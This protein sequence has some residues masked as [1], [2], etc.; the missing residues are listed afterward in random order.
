M[1]INILVFMG[2]FCFCSSILSVPLYMLSFVA[3]VFFKFKTHDFVIKLNV[4]NSI[5]IYLVVIIVLCGIMHFLFLSVDAFIEI[6]QII[7]RVFYFINF[8]FIY[9]F[10][11]EPKNIKCLIK[12]ILPYVF[13]FLFIYSVY[14][15]F[16]IIYSL[17]TLGWIVN[18]SQFIV[19]DVKYSPTIGLFRLSLIWSEPSYAAI[20]L[21]FS[22]MFIFIYNNKFTKNWYCYMMLLFL[23][24]ILT[25][26]R[27]LLIPFSSIIIY[28]LIR[29]FNFSKIHLESYLK[30]LLVILFFMILHIYFVNK[31]ITSGFLD[32]SYIARMNSIINGYKI[33]VDNPIVG[34]GFNTYSVFAK[35]STHLPTFSDASTS[36]SLLSSYLQQM[37]MFAILELFGVFYLFF[38]LDGICITRKICLLIFILGIGLFSLDV[39][40]LPVSYLFIAIIFNYENYLENK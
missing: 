17:P 18:N 27:S 1:F 26:S 15:V 2:N 5:I 34:T 7:I 39:L 30:Y 16:A 10:Y 29:K 40:Y 33:F 4:F 32:L 20:T 9:S 22:L 37:G 11:S 31:E 19:G 36:L 21:G 13:I 35:Y 28:L 38:K 23:G 12:Q 25:F 8:A 6:K 14:E 24:M 3:M